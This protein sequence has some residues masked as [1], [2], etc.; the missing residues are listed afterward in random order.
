[1]ASCK[2]CGRHWLIWG[3]RFGSIRGNRYPVPPPGVIDLLGQPLGERPETI[4]EQ[5]VHGQTSE[6]VL[7]L[8]AVELAVSLRVFLD[9][10]LNA[11]SLTEV[12]MSITANKE[13]ACPRRCSHPEN[14]MLQMNR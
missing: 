3:R 8:D 11:S 2:S 6:G 5:R 13:P 14:I 4:E 9:H 12:P 1:M 10:C 7:D